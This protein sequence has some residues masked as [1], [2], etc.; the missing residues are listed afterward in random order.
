M[1]SGRRTLY[2]SIDAAATRDDLAST[3]ASENESTQA[4]NS[5]ASPSVDPA[6][7]AGAA[8][9]L[10]VLQKETASA[11]PADAAAATG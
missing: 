1:G 9:L 11:S 5:N 6:V 3:P 4:G 7:D 10:E 8:L 2:V